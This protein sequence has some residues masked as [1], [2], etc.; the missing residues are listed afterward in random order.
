MKCP[1]EAN[2]QRRIDTGAGVGLRGRWGVTAKGL[3]ADE[4]VLKLTLV[5]S[6]NG[7]KAIELYIL[8]G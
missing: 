7:P 4:N 6:V 2:L 5:V 3:G 1:H 8:S